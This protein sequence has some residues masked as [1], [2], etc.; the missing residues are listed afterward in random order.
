MKIFCEHRLYPDEKTP[1][2]EHYSK[3]SD[4][5]IG[6]LPFFV[7]DNHN[8]KNKSSKEIITLEEAQNR[9]EI[10]KQ[11][12][13]LSNATIYGANMC[14]PEENEIY[15]YGKKIK[16]KTV[17]DSTSINDYKELHKA[18]KTSIGAYNN[19]LR[20]YDLL[21]ILN[22]YADKKNIWYPEEGDFDILTKKSI[23]NFLKENSIFKIIVEDEFFQTKKELDL[24]IL[25]EYEF[26]KEIIRNDF[27]IYSENKSILFSISWDDFFFL[28]AIDKNII[29]KDLIDC[30]FEGFWADERDTVLWDW[31]NG[32]IDR[33]LK[34]NVAPK[35]KSNFFKKI[36]NLSAILF[37][38]L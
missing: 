10:F 34:N 18:L 38:G 4:V 37:I 15:N 27:Y 8:C 20:R 12:E 33:L 32:E 30:F 35:S 24:N 19:Q 7:V 36:F 6:F 1:L 29:E 23:Y 9:H 14:Y 21:D 5:F 11:I 31:E 13:S 25:S 26:V 17:V 22:K 2:L 16:W 3:Y 28:I